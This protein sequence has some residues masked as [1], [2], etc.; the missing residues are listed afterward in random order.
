MKKKFLLIPLSALLFVSLASCGGNNSAT[1]TTPTTTAS[2]TTPT[3]TP[4]QTTTGSTTFAPGEEI[5]LLNEKSYI[6]TNAVDFENTSFIP[7]YKLK[8]LADVPYINVKDIKSLVSVMAGVN[9]NDSKVGNNIKLTKSGNENCYAI[10]DAL[11]N[12]ITLKNPGLLSEESDKS[13]GHDYCL[14]AGVVIRSSNKTKVGTVDKDEA[15]ISLNGYN[16]KLVSQN[17][18]IYAP[19]DL[20][21]VL[22]QPSSLIPFVYN[23]KDFFKNPSSYEFSDLSSLCFSGN[24]YFDYGYIDNNEKV[25]NTYKKVTTKQGQK[26]T[27]RAV[28]ID[29]NIIEENGKEIA[30]YSNGS[31]EI[32]DPKTGQLY[33]DF[34]N[35]VTKIKYKEENGYLIMYLCLTDRDNTTVVPSEQN[36]DQ[37]LIINLGET[38]FAKKERPQEVADFGYNLLCFSFDKVYSVKEA[39]GVSSFKTFFSEKGYE[40]DLKSTNIRTYEEA[41]AKLLN[42]EIDDGHTGLINVS[43]YDLPGNATIV[44]YNDKYKYKHT[45]EI[46]A[47]CNTYFSDRFSSHNFDSDSIKIVGDTAYLSFDSFITMGTPSNFNFFSVN[48]DIEEVRRM[49]TCGYMATAMI[50]IDDY[51]KQASNSVKVK[52]IVLD[53]TA[54]QGGDMTVLPYIS[55]IMTQDPK[56]CVN[57]TRTGQVIEYHYE[58]DFNGDGVYG[59]TYAD[60]YNF[61]MFTSDASFSCG[62]SLPSMVK[63]T[64]VKIIGM[65]GAGGASPITTFTDASGLVYKTSGQFGVCYKDGDTYK[66]IEGGVPVDV[67]IEKSLWYDYENLTKKID[68]LAGTNVK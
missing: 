54:N 53:I 25:A 15:K 46:L 27:Y 33:V 63:G 64:N 60:K 65:A 6:F 37:R 32:L 55:C 12:E 22:L 7:T 45:N 5:A 16:I 44:S 58:A 38:R 24:G 48:T 52:N 4:S 28:T 57:D 23:G 13:I 29:D 67:A 34:N 19:Y 1:T 30:L 9:L 17:N 40:A 8:G 41:F 42:T 11:N 31:G 10:F 18:E 39:K 49:D 2:T 68:E 50:K 61:F 35:K 21:N 59:D 3:T 14:T 66:S 26:Y 56:L 47:K 62:S 36:H 51:N 43:M 20:V